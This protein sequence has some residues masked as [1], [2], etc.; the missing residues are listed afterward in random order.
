M[1]TATTTPTRTDPSPRA[2]HP[3]YIV[4]HRNPDADA[5]CSAIAYAAYKAQRGETGYV[6][7]RCGNTNAR[8]D[9]IL[10]RFHQ[11]LPLY[12]SDVSLRGRDLMASAVISVTENSTCAE[13]LELIDRHDLRLLPVISPRRGIVGTVSLAAL[14]SFFI[15][16]VHDTRLMRQVQTSLANITR[17]LHAR[18]LHLVGERKVE[19][20]FV[21]L[22]TMDIR[23]FWS[24]SEREKI[25]ASQSIIIV[26]DRRDVQKRSIELGI[27]ALVITS[28]LEVEPE[29][30]E[31]AKAKG[32]SLIIS[33]YDSATTAWV[34][35]TASTLERVIERQVATVS[36]DARLVE[37]R[38][39]FAAGS[40]HALLVTDDDG[41]LQ[42][43]LT[44]S[45]L[46][47]PVQTR[48]VLV[49]HNEMTQAVPGAEEVTIT[50]VIDH[51]RLGS[52]NTQQPILFLNEPVGSTCTIVAD[53]FR[54]EG[55]APSPAIAGIMMAGLISDTLMLNSPTTTP[56]DGAVL[57]WLAG[58][59]GV[60][61]QKLA[62]EIFSSGSVILANPAARVV[63]S[64][65]K[66]YEEEGVRFAVSQVEEL[67]FG[68]F[69][70]HAKPI[71]AA[72]QELRT[73]ERLAFACLLVTDI[74]TQNSL[75]LVKGDEGL[76]RRISFAH[77]EQDEIFD[78]PG[79]V[80]R[81]KQLIP[82]L[83][84]LLREMAADG[85]LP[86]PAGATAAPFRRKK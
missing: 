29:V 8:I 35:R 2:A 49:D 77:V 71:A 85:A 31:L 40:P 9:T 45:D 79:I 78:L 76:I 26:G 52:L 55:L 11:P 65:F 61:A 75:L 86:A 5:I 27:R 13:A 30:V 51:H 81:K 59:A 20:L 14:G 21:R 32:V 54:R 22:G 10:A 68:N 24:I 67:G 4:G 23:S 19:E 42:G 39:K 3:T 7:A 73:D 60:D 50:E 1:T 83:G 53:L 28:N 57:A 17:A 34:V 25:P 66:V 63:R 6:A 16:R 41:A 70:A 64:D 72:L 33:P 48:L 74:N 43:I 36:A 46:L 15:P 84:S 82:Y 18:A 62:D 44:K 47:K 38:K 58:I 37:I 56:K 80:S 12:L 69:W